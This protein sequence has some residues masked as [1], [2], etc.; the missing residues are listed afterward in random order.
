MSETG[1]GPAERHALAVRLRRTED[2]IDPILAAGLDYGLIEKRGN[3]TFELTAPGAA[4]A[5]ELVHVLEAS[6]ERQLVRFRPFT[7]YTPERWWPER[8]TK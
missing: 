2:Q 3:N 1:H 6:S 8:I 5:S 4:L 7:E